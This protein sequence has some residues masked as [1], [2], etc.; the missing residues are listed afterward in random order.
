[1]GNMASKEFEKI[2]N[3]INDFRRNS[4]IER[5]NTQSIWENKRKMDIV[6][7]QIK[8]DKLFLET[9][10]IKK[11]F[12]EIKDNHLVTLCSVTRTEKVPIYEENIR[13]EKFFDYYEEKTF[14]HVYPAEII[15]SDN[16]DP[17]IDPYFKSNNEVSI[18][19]RFDKMSCGDGS[20]DYAETFSYKEIKARVINN[21]LSI[22]S[23]N[24][25]TI[26]E[27]ENLEFAIIKALKNS[28]NYL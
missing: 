19:L 25:S 22:D 21:K 26:V 18:K 5:R 23:E 13:G 11:I 9:S 28:L 27:D 4:E 12:E 8:K 7:E 14:P 3:E 20:F 15:E 1:M 6:L 10:G 16:N 24:S 17:S 2:K